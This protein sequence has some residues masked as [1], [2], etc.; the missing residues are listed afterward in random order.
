MFVLFVVLNDTE[1]LREILKVL[2]G[3]NLSCT[4]LDSI[5]ANQYVDFYSPNTVASFDAPVVVGSIDMAD[6]DVAVIYN[7]TLVAVAEDEQKVLKA[8]DAVERVVGDMAKPGTG[9]MFYMPVVKAVG[10]GK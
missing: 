4:V 10:I 8:M 5:S 6:E 1:Y 7:K 3:L 2:D 9:I